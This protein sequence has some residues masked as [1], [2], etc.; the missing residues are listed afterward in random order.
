MKQKQP[1][2][3]G[4]RVYYREMN[5]TMTNLWRFGRAHLAPFWRNEIRGES[6]QVF[7]SEMCLAR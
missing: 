5:K 7:G 2:R 6:L 3:T 4:A 1:K